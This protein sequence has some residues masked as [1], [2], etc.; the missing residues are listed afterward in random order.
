MLKRALVLAAAVV[1]LS[2]PFAAQSKP[3]A[4][5]NAKI[6]QEENSHSQI[7]RTLHVLTDVYGPRVT[8][9]PSLKA[10]GEW[11]IKQMESWG[12]ANGHLEP[13]D[14]G[15]PG[16]VNERLS[17]HIVSPVKD[18]LVSEVLAWTP[19]TNGPV[20]GPAVQITLPQRPTKE[21]LTAHLETLKDAV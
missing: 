16:W 2:A 13:W 17:A 14:F 8:G 18:H 1:M 20:R 12:F 10:A 3:D 19:S 15:R 21:A 5:I 11:A 7:M 6:R 9:S 4:D